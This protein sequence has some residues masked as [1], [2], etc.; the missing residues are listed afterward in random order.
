MNGCENFCSVLQE[1][2][3]NV[4]CLSLD[5]Y[6]VQLHELISVYCGKCT[7]SANK[8]IDGIMFTFHSLFQEGLNSPRLGRWLPGKERLF[9]LCCQ[10]AETRKHHQQVFLKLSRSDVLHHLH[11]KVWIIVVGPLA[12][13]FSWPL[14]QDPI[15]IDNKLTERRVESSFVPELAERLH[16]V[17]VPLSEVELIS[18]IHLPSQRVSAHLQERRE[19]LLLP[20][21]SLKGCFSICV[22][23][24]NVEN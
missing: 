15:C 12:A 14:Q 16:D 8:H 10:V 22:D 4:L 17:S 3:F 13:A 6:C 19:D 11:Q 18:L 20:P 9:V 2:P 24:Q 1:K 21:Q 7:Y 5:N 23:F